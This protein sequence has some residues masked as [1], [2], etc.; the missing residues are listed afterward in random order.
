M[1]KKF[2]ALA[3]MGAA[4]YLFKTKHGAEIRKQ[5]GDVAG[6]AA[7]GLREKYQQAGS[8]MGDAIDAQQS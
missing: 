7:Q 1:G 8:K 2:W 6:K 4:A 3:I 5:V